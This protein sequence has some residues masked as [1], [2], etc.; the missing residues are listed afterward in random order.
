[1]NVLRHMELAMRTAAKDM[2]PLW[3]PNAET[4]SDPVTRVV[5]ESDPISLDTELA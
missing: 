4:A 2:G 1:M 5:G 3:Q